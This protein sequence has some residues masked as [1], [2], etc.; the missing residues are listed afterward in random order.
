MRST[1]KCAAV[2]AIA[3][4]GPAGQQQNDGND[5]EADRDAAQRKQ[6]LPPR[7]RS[8]QEIV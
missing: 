7:T 6:Q 2:V 5:A 8:P 3:M 1:I 4:S